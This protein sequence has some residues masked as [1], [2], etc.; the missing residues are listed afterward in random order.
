MDR[1]I[2]IDAALS[3][4]EGDLELLTRMAG[5]F[6]DECPEL[7]LRMRDAARRGSFQ[8][9][10]RA[11][12]SL[13]SSMAIFGATAAYEAALRLERMSAAGDASGLADA[14]ASLEEEAARVMSEL[15][16]LCRKEA[17]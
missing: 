15:S 12:H 6:L 16:V 8:E 11:A 17:A 1:I 13:K 10:E 7:L 4:T 14:L 5:L 2:D 9:L 3:H